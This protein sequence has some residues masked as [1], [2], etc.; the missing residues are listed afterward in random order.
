MATRSELP[1]TIATITGGLEA[2]VHVG[3]QLFVARGGTTIA[4]LALGIARTGVAMATDTLM[5][6]MSACKPMAAVAIAQLWER[7]RLDLDDRVLQYIP[8]FDANG[9]DAVTIR[10][11]LTHTGGFRGITG[12]WERQPWDQII[13]AVCNAR[14][15]PGWAPG[16]KAGYHVA[17]SWYILAEIVRRLD[18]REFPQY[19]REMILEPLGMNDSWIGMPREQY[20]AYGDRIGQMHDT[21][22]ASPKADLFWDTEDGA[23]LCRP[24]G[25]GRGPIRE[26]GR[27]YQALLN[28]GEIDGSRILS[29]QTV[30][31]IISP[32]RVG[33]YDH[34]FR[35]VMDWGLGF[36]VNSARY[37]RDSVPYGFGPHASDRTF[38]HSGH[39]STVAFADRENQLVVALVCNGMP[40]EVRHH[41][42]M[43][44]ILAAIYEDLGLTAAT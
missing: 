16:R 7:G 38:G 21:A 24:A 27:F 34:T 6:W 31:A 28:K 18:G 30:E 37:G 8:E 4:D 1:R 5:I 25:N 33:M 32:H 20:R 22:G 15:E 39:Q 43:R 19:V 9:K 17:T 26:L 44:E 14:L 40:G 12:E 2:G 10:H 3:A 29:P 13:A 41:I 11:L 23:A 42:R 36:I 35:H